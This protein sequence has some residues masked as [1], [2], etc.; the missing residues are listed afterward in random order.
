M[1]DGQ[2]ARSVAAG[3]G[4]SRWLMPEPPLLVFRSLAM[5]V[6]LNQAIILQQ[7]HWALGRSSTERI[8]GEPWLRV[9]MPWFEE[10]FPFWSEATIRRATKALVELKLVVSRRTR[11]GN[12]YRIDYAALDAL[13]T[14]Q[15]ATLADQSDRSSRERVGLLVREEE[16]E[17]QTAG[18]V[19]EPGTLFTPPPP[20]VP[21]DETDAMVQRIW[22]HYFGHFG[23][24]LT[25]KTL[26]PARTKTLR[27]ALRAVDGDAD[28]LCRAVDGFKNYRQRKAGST[29]VDDI[30]KS[31]PGGSSLTELVEF[32][33]SQADDSPTIAASV[34]A[35]L[36]EKVERRRLTIIESLQR[37]GDEAAQERAQEAAD[38]LLEHAKERPVIEGSR[39]V[40][41]ERVA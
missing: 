12:V 15:S 27:S 19:D 25:I 18:A 5:A 38:W 4:G 21:P 1:G 23:D 30:F 35:I 14:G 41:W 11:N 2:S 20:E 33:I 28:A 31:R 3:G 10:Q 13:P 37:P 26:T 34:P 6:G 22:D 16:K 24:G 29:S 32:W 7:M 8:D 17:Q 39:V 40:R 36:R 9:S